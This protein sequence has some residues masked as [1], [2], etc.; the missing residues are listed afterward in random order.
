MKQHDAPPPGFKLAYEIV[1][2]SEE[3]A[4][5]QLMD[6]SD[7]RCAPYDPGNARASASFGWKYL[8]AADSFERCAPIP[9]G[10]QSIAGKAAAF[11]GLEVDDIAECLLNRY[12]PG[13]IIQPHFDKPVFEHVIGVS[14]GA[15]S[16]MHFRKPGAD[17]DDHRAVELPRRSIY[18]LAGQARDTY[19]HSL[20]PIAVTRWSLTFRS[21]SEVGVRLRD[22]VAAG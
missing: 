5:I 22:G 16:V 10:L 11:A 2:P 8:F 13:A 17:G 9:E 20:P 3:E 4:L 14:L 7:L 1:S 15:T 12:E 6:A 19:Q 18:L 21:L